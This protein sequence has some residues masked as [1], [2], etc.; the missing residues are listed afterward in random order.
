MGYYKTQVTY[1]KLIDK[2]MEEPKSKNSNTEGA[3]EEERGVDNFTSEDDELFEIN[4]EE[5][6]KSRSS[7]ENQFFVDNTEALLANCTL[8]VSCLCDAIPFECTPIMRF[9]VTPTT[10]DGRSTR[11]TYFWY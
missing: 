11:F 4:L 8:P 6:R 5:V 9:G 1:V 2:E 7:S 3:V 10:N